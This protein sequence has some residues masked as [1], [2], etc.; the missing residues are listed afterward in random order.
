MSEETKTEI[1]EFLSHMSAEFTAEASV[2][3]EGSEAVESEPE[4]TENPAKGSG[5]QRSGYVSHFAPIRAADQAGINA[6]IAEIASGRM[7]VLI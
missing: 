1:E 2:Q 7:R 5:I 4:V 3:P 6:H